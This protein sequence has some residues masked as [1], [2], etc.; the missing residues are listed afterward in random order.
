MSCLV[1][2]SSRVQISEYFPQID[3]SFIARSESI[4]NLIG[5]Y[6]VHICHILEYETLELKCCTQKDAVISY[7]RQIVNDQT[8]D[9]K[10]IET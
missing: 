6:R 7:W 9:V 4:C 5:C 8:F 10:H 3:F 2:S 1:I